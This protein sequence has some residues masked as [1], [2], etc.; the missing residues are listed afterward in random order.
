MSTLFWLLF[1]GVPALLVWRPFTGAIV[2]DV[3][4]GDPD[5]SDWLMG[6]LL[7][8]MAA[9]VWP[10]IVFLLLTTK[11]FRSLPIFPYM[12]LGK[13]RAHY[14]K[15]QERETRDRLAEA[16]AEQRRLQRLV[17][18]YEHGRL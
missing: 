17:D 14:Q 1:W 18:E 5:C 7:G 12:T 11:A 3:V 16:Q 13:E 8:G 2:Y 15:I 6:S 4:F 9:C 10:V